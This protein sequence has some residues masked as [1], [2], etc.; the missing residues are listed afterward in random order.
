MSFYQALTSN[1]S[2]ENLGGKSKGIV[3]LL[4]FGCS[5][6]ESLALN[7]KF[8]DVFFDFHNLE[9]DH[10]S[11]ISDFSKVD[12][13]ED[14]LKLKCEEAQKKIYALEYPPSLIPVL[15]E[16]HAYYLKEWDYFCIRSSSNE[17]DGQKTA[18]AGVFESYLKLS[19]EKDLQEYV[20]KAIAQVFDYQVIVNSLANNINPQNL[21]MGILIQE[22]SPCDKYGV[23]FTHN[24][25]NANDNL[26]LS[27]GSDGENLMS[28]E[29]D[30]ETIEIER[31]ALNE[32][33]KEL[34]QLI[35][36][37][38]ELESK[39][40][41]PQDIEWGL[42][43]NK[44]TFFQMRPITTLNEISK[45]V[46]W[47]REL[48]EERYP[49]PMSPLGW[50]ILRDVFETNLKTL[51]KR[52]GLI[53]NS[54]DDVAI[55]INHYVFVNDNFFAIS[56]MKPHFLSLLPVFG[57][58][59]IGGLKTLI[60]SPYIIF[61]SLF[62][63]SKLGLR[64]FFIMQIYNHFILAHAKDI[65][66][67]WDLNLQ[68]LIK[69]YDELADKDLGQMDL[70]QL[71]QFRVD[72]EKVGDKYM[73]PDLAIYVVKSA[74]EWLI[75]RIATIYHPDSSAEEYLT[76]VT[77][78]L[79]NNR[80][81][82]MAETLDEVVSTVLENK[83]LSKLVEENQDKEFF[84][85]LDDS[86]QKSLGK[87][88]QLNGHLTVNWDF[89]VPTWEEN[90]ND[91]FQLLR[92]LVN[93]KDRKS[94]SNQVQVNNE[95]FN[96]EVSN[97]TDEI[98]QSFFIGKFHK[99]LLYHL[100]EFM[101]IDEEHHFYCSRVF[102]T[103]RKLYI[104]I[105]EELVKKG[106]IRNSMDIFYL[107]SQEIDSMIES[108]EY[109]SRHYLV[110]KRGRTFEKSFDQTPAD[111][112][113]N[114]RAVF[115]IIESEG[116][117]YQGTGASPGMVTG[118]VKIIKSLSDCHKISKGDIIVTQSP[119]PVF[120]PLY[121]VAA[122]LVSNTGS[123]LSHGLVAAREYELPAVIGIPNIASIL[124]ENQRITINGNTGTITIDD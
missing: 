76:S 25:T 109:F 26:I 82:E 79:E 93:N 112:Y 122:G 6:P 31:K 39:L 81:I 61:Q 116:N 104:R 100:R 89:R 16:I 101:R 113:E 55:T 24:P 35:T 47:S 119:N 115:Q 77:L 40:A 90:K 108:K 91:F 87:F 114:G 45:S 29:G 19:G 42:K 110:Q 37:A 118:T 117:N 120:V 52:F 14:D 3:S 68:P 30:S 103:L 12:L 66:N 34:S 20:K 107:K 83:E 56:N 92:S 123:T 15:N 72:L 2:E 17:E 27:T 65:L 86:T 111:K 10:E 9:K 71:A 95:N 85:S 33:P 44:L 60:Y 63:K 23:L 8:F 4:K 99:N 64:D 54:P 36:I 21:K 41:N 57:R 53:A 74:C 88:M 62:G 38:L 67:Q 49:L 78:G 43:D 7:T 32:A 121:S 11:L 124:K 94:I 70:S 80:T 106:V 102:K 96:K 13:T 1:S 22:F 84:N 51:K 59:I 28:G 69:Q 48:A 5:T 73:E 50:S 105:G 58:V 18:F 97:L 75:K 46:L 98:N